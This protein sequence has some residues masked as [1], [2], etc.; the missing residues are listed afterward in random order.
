MTVVRDDELIRV[1]PWVR[2]FD[3]FVTWMHTAE[4]PDDVRIDFLNGD[5]WIDF[6]MEELYSHNF[7]KSALAETVNRVVREGRLGIFVTGG[8]RFTNADAGTATVPDAMYIASD[9]LTAGRV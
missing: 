7:V 2:D 9:T 3:T 6:S 8:M 4:F 5:V 1:P